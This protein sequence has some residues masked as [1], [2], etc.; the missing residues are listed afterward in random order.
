M[1]G[2]LRGGHG[3]YPARCLRQDRLAE[4]MEICYRTSRRRSHAISSSELL[5]R[6]REG[7]HIRRG[8]GDDHCTA[9]RAPELRFGYSHDRRLTITATPFQRSRGGK[10]RRIDGPRTPVLV[11]VQHLDKRHE[12]RLHR[13]RCAAFQRPAV[14]VISSLG[15]PLPRDKGDSTVITG[16]TGFSSLLMSRRSWPSWAI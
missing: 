14:L 16:T 8:G 12:R 3:G 9:L 11:I 1:F 4:R 5:R 13:S 7:S 2:I 15:H 10:S 6:G